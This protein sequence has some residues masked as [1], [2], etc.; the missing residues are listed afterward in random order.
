MHGETLKYERYYFVLY[1]GYQDR[2]LKMGKCRN[3]WHGLQWHSQH[4]TFCLCCTIP[5]SGKG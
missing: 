2:L 5:T 4:K 3:L 1:E